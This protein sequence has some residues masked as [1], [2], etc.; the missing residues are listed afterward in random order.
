MSG[1]DE[2]AVIRSA[3]NAK[4][5][6]VRAVQ[7]GKEAGWIVLEG[8]RLV[9]DAAASGLALELVLVAEGAL[10][11]ERELAGGERVVE[12]VDAELLAR[13]SGLKSGARVVALAREPELGDVAELA[14]GAEDLVLVVDGVQDPANLGALVRSAEAAGACAVVHVRG[15]AAPFHARAL[16]GSMGSA[17]RVPA[18]VARDRDAAVAA[19]RGAGLRIVRPDTRGGRDWRGFDWSGAVALW[20]GG[21]VAAAAVEGEGVSIAM[22]GGV[23]SLNVTVAASLLL[24]AAG[25][26][27]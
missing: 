17:L 3:Q 12:F 18:F 23:E 1:W 14:V 2:G 10:E 6:R 24:F 27:R 8:E 16:R 11:L 15:G 20:I 13:V 19:V 22:A 9:R 21:E 25:R 4:V 5:K 26:V 7:A